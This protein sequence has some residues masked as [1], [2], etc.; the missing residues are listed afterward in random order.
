MR[1]TRFSGHLGGGGSAQGR[2]LLGGVSPGGIYTP[3]P[4]A[5][6]DTSPRTELLTHACENTTFPQLLL[7]AVIR[8]TLHF[9]Y[10]ENNSVT[11][12]K[13]YMCMLPHTSYF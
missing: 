3:L 9:K 5:C 10:Q 7:W 11:K 13:Q 2:C 4:I 12:Y 8:T 1:T 6:W